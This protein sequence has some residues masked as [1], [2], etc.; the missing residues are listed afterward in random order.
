MELP[1][2]D[3]LLIERDIEFTL[4]F[5]AGPLSI[6]KKADEF[7]VAA[8]VESLGDVV[9]CRTGGAL[10]LIP[11]AEVLAEVAASGP[12]VTCLASLRASCQASM[13]SNFVI[14]IVT[15]SVVVSSLVK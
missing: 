6:S 10:N 11:E 3:V 7:N 13:S 1:V 5:G 14:F 12:R 8:A 15:Q 9:H 4:Y 2:G